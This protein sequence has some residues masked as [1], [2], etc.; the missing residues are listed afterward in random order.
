MTKSAMPTNRSQIQANTVGDTIYVTGGRTAAAYSTVGFTEAYNVTSGSWST[1]ASMPY[2]V[3][4]AVSAAIGAKI[5][6]VGG[7]DEWE[8]TM[9]LNT[10]QV[11]DTVTD[12]W[13]FGSPAPAVIWGSGGAATLGESASKRF[14]VFGGMQGFAEPLNYSFVYNPETDSWGIAPALP[15]ARYGPTV[16]VVHDCL[17]AIGGGIGFPIGTAVNEQYVPEDYGLPVIPEFTV[18]VVLPLALASVMGVLVYFRT[19]KRLMVS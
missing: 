1:K 9:N 12:S 13:S 18:W 16:A 6:V 5:Y 14:Y 19:R 3:V 17:Y 8:R 7:Q 2:P 4:S 11:Y 10:L 15:T